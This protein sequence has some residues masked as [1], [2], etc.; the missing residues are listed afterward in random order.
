M[1]GIRKALIDMHIDMI[2]DMNDI[3]PFIVELAKKSSV[4]RIIQLHILLICFCKFQA[5]MYLVKPSCKT[6]VR[7][8]EIPCPTCPTWS[9]FI[10][11]KLKIYI[12]LSLDKYKCIKLIQFCISYFDYYELTAY[13][14]NGVDP[15]Q[16]PADLDLHC[17]HEK[18]ADQAGT[19]LAKN[20]REK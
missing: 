15:D 12:Y 8:V 11:D 1:E 16:L 14:G 9:H 13:I 19:K 4:S 2:V 5:Y 6:L 3:H 20:F 17:L 10:Q 7:A 18:P